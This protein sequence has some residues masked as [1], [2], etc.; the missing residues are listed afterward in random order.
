MEEDKQTT[1]VKQTNEQVGDTSVRR[2]TVAKRTSV[3]G[4][5]VFQRVIW[6][7]AGVILVLL[8]LRFVLLLLGANDT[9]G[10][11]SFIYTVSG[12]FAAP[13]YGIFSYEPSY[14]KS[15]FEVS[16]LVAMAVYALVAWGIAKL[17]TL[18]RPHEEV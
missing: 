13:F 15:V 10:F 2:E 7:L 5:V 12:L 18:A 4:V 17:A 14:G 1:E 8:A 3:S 11:V 6:Y 16:T 9:N